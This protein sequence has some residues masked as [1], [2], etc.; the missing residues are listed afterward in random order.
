MNIFCF[1]GAFLL[2][3]VSTEG[4]KLRIDHIAFPSSRF[5]DIFFPYDTLWKLIINR[6]V[7]ESTNWTTSVIHVTVRLFSGIENRTTH[8]ATGKNKCCEYRELGARQGECKLDNWQTERLLVWLLTEATLL[9][10][11]NRLG[12]ES[13]RSHGGRAWRLR[14]ERFGLL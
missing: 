6:T 14:E 3:V 1:I 9:A 5:D 11:G 13:S 2:N 12:R 7:M 4:Q 8:T 10:W